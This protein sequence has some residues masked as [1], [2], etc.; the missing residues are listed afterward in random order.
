MCM[1]YSWLI[2]SETAF[3][4]LGWHNIIAEMLAMSQN[5]P[6]WAHKHGPLGMKAAF[7]MP[8]RTLSEI[9][10]YCHLSYRYPRGLPLTDE[11]CF[12]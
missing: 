3:E 4:S 9:E 12:L 6:L 2:P 11:E 8:I 1:C 7:C 5:S 10:I